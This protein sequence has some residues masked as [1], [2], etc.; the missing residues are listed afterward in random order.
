MCVCVIIHSVVI[1]LLLYEIL[2]HFP[3]TRH[4][5]YTYEYVFTIARLLQSCVFYN[6]FVV[7]TKQ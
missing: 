7:E 3:L 4:S 5:K 6:E 2:E 1:H